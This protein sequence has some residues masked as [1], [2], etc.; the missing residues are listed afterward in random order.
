[1]INSL[2]SNKT[3]WEN[4]LRKLQS[5]DEYGINLKK[6][7]VAEGSERYYAAKRMLNEKD[8]LENQTFL[9]ALKEGEKMMLSL[10]CNDKFK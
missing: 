1:M 4:E 8:K 7:L 3:S 9:L 6:L 5:S 2:K 10:E